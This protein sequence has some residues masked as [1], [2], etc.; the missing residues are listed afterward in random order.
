MACLNPWMTMSLRKLACSHLFSALEA[1]LALQRLLSGDLASFADAQTKERVE[2]DAWVA[3]VQEKLSS[4]AETSLKEACSVC[5]PEMRDHQITPQM[6]RRMSS[7][8]QQAGWAK[9]GRFT[10]GAQ[11]NQTRFKKEAQEPGFASI[12]DEHCD[13]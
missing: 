3:L 12:P 5:F 6:T 1:E 11:R 4:K 13:F 10:S 8:L 2:E 7:C 9:D